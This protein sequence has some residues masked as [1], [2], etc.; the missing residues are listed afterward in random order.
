MKNAPEGA[1]SDP[2]WLA[3]AGWRDVLASVRWRATARS[4]PA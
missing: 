1:S 3:E 4:L 2:G